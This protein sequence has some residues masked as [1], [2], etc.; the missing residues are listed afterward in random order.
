MSRIF[1][2]NSGLKPDAGGPGGDPEDAVFSA[3]C[4]PAKPN[5][6]DLTKQKIDTPAG[7]DEYGRSLC[8]KT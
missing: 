2:A 3:A 6:L 7:R 4:R 1:K 8:G 5:C